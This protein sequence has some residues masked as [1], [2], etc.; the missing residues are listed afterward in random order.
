M[1][2][3][4]PFPQADNLEKVV[5]I[6][7]MDD[8]KKLKNNYLISLALDNI[9]MRQVNYYISAAEYLGLIYNRSFTKEGLEFRSLYGNDQKVYLAY[10]IF[11]MPVFYRALATNVDL[12][13]FMKILK[14]Y[15]PDMNESMI[16]RRSQTGIA[17]IK[18]FNFKTIPLISDGPLLTSKLVSL[19]Y[20][21]EIIYGFETTEEEIIELSKKYDCHQDSHNAWVE[22]RK[23]I[24][25]CVRI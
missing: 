6:A 3:I 13:G 18:Y 22:Y 21:S 15:Y 9:T 24:E 8:E 12:S 14:E 2:K 19:A 10:L 25:N 16:K 20:F 11:R 17:W 5:R 1:N 7:K 23:L 4:I